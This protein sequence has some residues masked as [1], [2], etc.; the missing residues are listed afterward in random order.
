CFT[1]G[2][3]MYGIGALVS[4]VSPSLGVLIL[5]NSVLEGVGT[6]LLIPPVYILTTLRFRDTTSRARAFGVISGLGGIG[7]AAGPL[8][9][10]LITTGISWRAAFIFQ[11]LVVATIVVLSRRVDDPVPPDPKR[12]FDAVG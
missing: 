11:A 6:A 10:G 9:G 7:A 8:I 12:P 3:V 4:A 5:G 2:L 1:I